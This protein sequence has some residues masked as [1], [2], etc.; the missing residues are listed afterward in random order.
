MVD[1]GIDAVSLGRDDEVL[2][3]LREIVPTYQPGSPRPDGPPA[4][5]DAAP[6]ARP[7]PL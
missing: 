6:D 1:E 5:L 7:D 2:R 3:I 4:P